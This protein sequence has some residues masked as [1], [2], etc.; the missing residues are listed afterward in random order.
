MG[1]VVSAIGGAVGNVLGGVGDIV[2]G[3]LNI[4]G[5]VVE[6]VGD[7]GDDVLQLAGDA[8]S[9]VGDT[10]ENTVKGALDN[11]IGTIAKVAAIAT[12]QYYLLPYISAA[13]T[14]AH[15]GDLGDI[16]KSAAISYVANEIAT[17]VAGV[18][19]S[20]IGGITVDDAGI[21]LLPSDVAYNAAIN[22]GRGVAGELG[23]QLGGNI[24]GGAAGSAF[25]TAVRGGDLDQI[26]MSSISGGAGAGIATSLSELSGK[27]NIP[28][29]A[30]PV[31]GAAGVGGVNAL[32]KGDSIADGVLKGATV[33]GINSAVSIASEKVQ[34]LYGK[35]KEYLSNYE[36]NAAK[37]KETVDKANEF[38]E[39]TYKPLADETK[40][41]Y[42]EIQNLN[43]V[44]QDKKEALEEVTKDYD[45][46]QTKANE[47]YGKLN[48]LQ[49]SAQELYDRASSLK[50]R[51]EDSKNNYDN[52]VS[53]YE[54]IKEQYNN[55]D[56]YWE[57]NGYIKSDDKWV[58]YTWLQP[59][60]AGYVT[61]KQNTA[62]GW[63][64]GWD[65][66]NFRSI[67]APT[68]DA[69]YNQATSLSGSIKD[70]ATSV[71]SLAQ[72]YT[73]AVNGY[74]GVKTQID[75]YLPQYNNY[76]SQ[77]NQITSVA[78]PMVQELNGLYADLTNKNNYYNSLVP[79][80]EEAKSTYDSFVKEAE[81]YKSLAE[82]AKS[83]YN[84]SY[85]DYIESTVDLNQELMDYTKDVT[86]KYVENTGEIPDVNTIQQF[87]DSNKS[88]DELVSE[89]KNSDSG[90]VWS[91]MKEEGADLGNVLKSGLYSASEDSQSLL[92]K[93]QSAVEN[94]DV[95]AASHY[96]WQLMQNEVQNNPDNGIFVKNDDGSITNMLTGFKYDAPNSGYTVDME[97]LK[98][99]YGQNQANLPPVVAIANKKENLEIGESGYGGG[100]GAGVAEKKIN[101]DESIFFDDGSAL[102]TYEDGTKGM[103][104]S[105]GNEISENG[106]AYSKVEDFKPLYADNAYAKAMGDFGNPATWLDTWYQK[107]SSG[108]DNTTGF[109]SSKG[110]TATPDGTYKDP[111]G[112]EYK[113]VTI[114]DKNYLQDIDDP[115]GL[116][117][118]GGGTPGG[119]TGGTPGGTTG[120][121][122]GGTTDGTPGGTTDGTPGGTTDG[123]GPGGPGGAGGTGGGNLAGAL[124]AADYIA[125]NDVN[126][127]GIV[128]TAD[129]IAATAALT[130][131]YKQGQR[132]QVVQK[133]VQGMRRPI[134]AEPAKV[135]QGEQA[136]LANLDTFNPEDPPPATTPN[137]PTGDL[138]F[139]ES[140][141]VNDNNLG[142]TQQTSAQPQPS[143]S[144]LFF[145]ESQ[146][147]QAAEGGQIE[148]N[149]Q[150]FSEGGLGTLDNRYVRGEGDGTSD[151]VPAML[152]SGEFVIPADVVS[153][154]GNGD[155]D[156]GAAVLDEFMK[157]IRIHKRAADPSELPEDSKGPL[158]YLQ[159]AMK[160]VRT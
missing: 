94:N 65:F 130:G 88:V 47:Y 7:I 143:Q 37:N 96:R 80:V 76:L 25:N 56:T 83:N 12:Q 53:S 48:P 20:S 123:T 18:E 42:D 39:N 129:S 26:L 34:S 141:V 79:K 81:T 23:S 154:L 13:D 31:L 57:N 153:G 8:I 116:Y 11:P 4:V 40:T 19:S 6:T 122:P 135:I 41:A 115:S 2:G 109:A 119:T 159:E 84:T 92:T 121:T 145:D 27:Y 33:G 58:K 139:D 99:A 82:D 97:M 117:E 50:D 51:Y 157:A 68:K 147:R 158:A 101:K 107:E 149:P 71:N 21:A 126:K 156:A 30:I 62:F 134:D 14:A 55:Y 36:T 15:G 151:S 150:F 127:D 89:I 43:G 146:I 38:A 1:G 114:G 136:A 128:N 70:Y 32:L 61:P 77:L 49:S 125:K 132:Q 155:N 102:L 144:N 95:D 142:T 9:F 67:E 74:N 105:D 73:S 44:Y 113:K 85:V 59:G 148:H 137:Q 10:L 45:Y 5:D 131:L 54:T 138:Y 103:F 75:Q 17:D 52:A 60:D 98:A 118:I 110:L 78:E 22:A 66:S 64:G 93:L 90:I 112:N 120:G 111:S 3:A 87:I 46:L 16:A 160:K 106:P 152:A 100:L 104:D 28:K 29:S 86:E 91:D 124:E 24:A 35:T 63:W 69:L 108:L 140:Q 72:D 133:A